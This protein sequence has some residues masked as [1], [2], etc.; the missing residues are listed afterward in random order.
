MI[1]HIKIITIMK[2]KLFLL[3]L[4]LFVGKI[5]ATNDIVTKGSNDKKTYWGFGLS[6][7]IF[8]L[9][10]GF[11]AFNYYASTISDNE[12]A[13]SNVIGV[14]NQGSTGFFV[15]YRYQYSK[16]NALAIRLKYN[17][18]RMDYVLQGANDY[19]GSWQSNTTRIRNIE[20]P[21]MYRYTFHKGDVDLLT[22]IVGV[23]ADIII[24]SSLMS[25]KALTNV[26]YPRVDGEFVLTK[27][28][29]V[30]P[31]FTVGFSVDKKIGN[32]RLETALLVNLYPLND[33]Y[34]YEF[35]N[36]KMGRGSI[37]N[38]NS[39]SFDKHNIEVSIAY[40]L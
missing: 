14:R 24:S 26:L 4:L 39:E 35:V 40:Y 22:G 6:T 3:V 34:K 9:D 21:L 19:I 2:T 12:L 32:H 28:R 30:N 15:D 17:S 31:F 27:K 33:N 23:G 16:W 36:S 37:Y 1:K 38:A 7:N 20:I 11:D 29:D 10:R 18:R 13:K 25:F 8:C 5:Y